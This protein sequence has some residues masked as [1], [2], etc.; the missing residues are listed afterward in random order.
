MFKI[1]GFVV[2]Q[3]NGVVNKL[4]CSQR[5][6]HMQTLVVSWLLASIYDQS[7]DADDTGLFILEEYTHIPYA[8]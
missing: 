4:L 3:G 5:G 7:C 8:F 2:F 6:I 1:S